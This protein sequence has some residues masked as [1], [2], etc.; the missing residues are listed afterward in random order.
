M[1]SRM[2]SGY[3]FFCRN[4]GCEKQFES[5][6]SMTEHL[7]SFHG[8]LQ[9]PECPALLSN[10][11]NLKRHIAN[12]HTYRPKLECEIC[13]MQVSKNFDNLNRHRRSLHP[14]L[15][16]GEEESADEPDFLKSPQTDFSSSS[17]DGGDENKDE[18]ELATLAL[19]GLKHLASHKV[20]NLAKL[21]IYPAHG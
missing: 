4:R 15:F 1:R 3:T 6:K 12:K 18:Q 2:D 21:R 9:C 13:G 11:G 19:L 17:K 14:E 10:A 16:S 5:E 20:G 8:F 7:V